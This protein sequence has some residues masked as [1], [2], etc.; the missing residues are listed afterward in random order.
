MFFT[1]N[2]SAVIRW[3]RTSGVRLAGFALMLALPLTGGCGP[4]APAA[5]TGHS[6]VVEPASASIPPAEAAALGALP[7]TVQFTEITREAGIQFTHF[8]GARGKKY[9]PEIET[10]GCAFIDYDNNGRPDIL[11]LNGADW[12]EVKSGRKRSLLKLY[13][14]EGNCRFTDVTS[15]SGLGIEMHTMGVAVGDYDNDGYDDLY[16]TCVIGPSRLFRNDGHGRFVDVTAQAGV[17]NKSRWGSGAAWL[18]YDKDGKLDLVVGNYCKWSPQTDVRCSVYG[19]LKSYCTPNVYDGESVRLYHNEGA[20]RFAEVTDRAGL[21][22][23]PGKTWGVVILDYDDDGWMDIALANDM[24]PNCLYHNEKDGT[25]REVALEAGVAL[26]ANG[27]AKA[28]MGVDAGDIDNSGRPSLI[29]SNFTGEGLSLFQNQGGGQFAES[30]HAWQIADVSLLRMGWGLFFFDYDLDGRLD[31]LAANGHLYENVHM[32]QPDVT[33]KEPPLLLHNEGKRFVDVAASHGAAIAR[34]I[35]A[36][37]SSYADIDGDGDLDVLLAENDGPAHLLRNEGGN[38]NHWLRIR[39]VGSN[40]NRNG[41]GAKVVAEAKGV[42]QTRWVKSAASFLSSSELTVTFG[43]G[44]ISAADKVTITWP[45]GKVDTH[46]A[47]KSDQVVVAREGGD[48]TPDNASK[49]AAN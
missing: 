22:Y 2:K 33:F 21:V 4:K 17:D 18:D 6:A 29:V 1:E 44:Q 13:K 31:A 15:S 47:V 32:F 39:T 27:V 43:L 26:G 5:P 24:E 11:L 41:I 8:S 16:I 35:V 12:P 49:S 23:R 10:P 3:G 9:M 30:S 7:D 19:G 48:M 20:G 45:S 14:N 46:T 28:G 36:R 34:P 25:F 40:S 37:G 42:K 38:K